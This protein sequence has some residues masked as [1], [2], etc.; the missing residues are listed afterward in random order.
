MSEK[1]KSSQVAGTTSEEV[2]KDLPTYLSDSIKEQILEALSEGKPI[3]IS[4]PH[5]PTGKTHLKRLLINHGVV[6]FEEWEVQRIILKEFID[7]QSL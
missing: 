6:A 1:N 2:E 3:I 7:P 5:G 4:G